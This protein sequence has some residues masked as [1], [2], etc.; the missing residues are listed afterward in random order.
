MNIKWSKI[1]KN[2]NDILTASKE[3]FEYIEMSVDYIT[4]L[5]EEEFV[6]LKN[7]INEKNIMCE[8]CHSILPLN[9]SVTEDGFNIYVWIDHLKKAAFRA[10]ELGCKTFI[11]NSGKARLLPYEEDT[12]NAKEQVF[13]FL[14]MV[15]E[16]LSHYNIKLLIE[17]LGP[18]HVNYINTM[19]E[20]EELLG[21]INKENFSSLISVSQ[22]AQIDFQ[23]G[24]F[25]KYESIIKHI[26]CEDPIK[27]TNYDYDDI[28]NGIK[29]MKCDQIISLPNSSTKESL[30]YCKKLLNS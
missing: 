6:F 29:N 1:A 18:A 8:T 5:S 3:G 13:Q 22:L 12:G 17:P 9:V 7:L 23:S 25:N 15:C 4:T 14:Y 11:W 19:A 21:L 28:F 2:S 27:C 16:L 30:D 26:Y 24:D 20:V 10:S